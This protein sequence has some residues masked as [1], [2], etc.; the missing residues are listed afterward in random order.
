MISDVLKGSINTEKVVTLNGNLTIQ[1]HSIGGDIKPSG[2]SLSTKWG[3]IKGEIDN[4]L[5]LKERLDEKY[6]DENFLSMTNTE[7]DNLFK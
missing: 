3:K 7:I 2:G 5:D 1:S 6:D 4:Q